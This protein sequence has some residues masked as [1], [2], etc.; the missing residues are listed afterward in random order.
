MKE[1]PEEYRSSDIDIC[2]GLL[3]CKHRP[4]RIDPDH[5][6]E[7]VLVYIWDLKSVQP[8]LT[9]L[10]TNQPV[11]IDIRDVW[12][13]DKIWVMNIRHARKS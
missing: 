10:L 6:N 13:G 3:Y 1:Q 7:Q 2:K 11:L 9:L 5:N 12:A 4:L 8:D